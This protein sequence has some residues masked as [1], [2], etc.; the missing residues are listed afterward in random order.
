MIKKQIALFI[1]IFLI[2][3]ELYFKFISN[4]I[5]GFVSIALSIAGKEEGCIEFLDV[6][7]QMIRYTVQNIRVGIWNCGS[8]NLTEINVRVNL[9]DINNVTVSIKNQTVL[10]MYLNEKRAIDIP[11][12]VTSSPGNYELL[13]YGEYFN[14]ISNSISTPITI[15]P[16]PY[17]QPPAPSGPFPAPKK[18]PNITVNYPNEINM[19]PD[20]EYIVLIR[21]SNTG[22]VKINN[23]ELKLESS[24]I[25]TQIIP[26]S[27][28]SV[29]E[30]GS[31]VIFTTKIKASADIKPR[32]YYVNLYVSSD[33]ILV[34]G[35]I[36]I[37]VRTLPL[38]EE[39]AE[40]IAYYSSVLDT[41]EDDI[42]KAENEGKNVTEARN[43][44]SDAKKELDI[45]KNLFNLGMYSSSINQMENV[46]E[47]II[48]LVRAIVTAP[49]I[50]KQIILP[51]LPMIPCLFWIIVLIIVDAIV[52]TITKK[53]KL[54]WAVTVLILLVIS[55]V[56]I[57]ISGMN[58]LSWFII[59]T[60]LMILLVAL[61]SKG[62]RGEN[63]RLTSFNRW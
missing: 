27:N 58:C 8:I 10:N 39:A 18:V 61:T 59:S 51:A 28:F 43:L 26:P 34:T 16:P 30:I 6:S 2:F 44:L 50:S 62:I 41:L 17:I 31:S 24:E 9:T 38:K 23:L 42:K 14:G 32:T 56:I 55:I 40:L 49:L 35:K 63:I 13:V 22:N 25:Q 36:T 5:T 45:A 52:I 20:S 60:L 15:L 12:N 29:M 1:I 46:K 33:E 7:S 57:L 54:H 4:M 37:N 48:E 21:V 47:K 19:T 3:L 53:M 11:W